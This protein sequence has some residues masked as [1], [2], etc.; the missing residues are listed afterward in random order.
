LPAHISQTILHHHD[1][2]VFNDPKHP[3]TSEVRNFIA[4]LILAEHLVSIFMTAEDKNTLGTYPVH[5]HAFEHL[6]LEHEEFF[7]IAN[8]IWSELGHS[9]N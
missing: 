4:V 2:G 7:D 8:D 1:I 6:G 9:H 3:A 5:A